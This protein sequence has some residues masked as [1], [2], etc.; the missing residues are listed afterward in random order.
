MVSEISRIALFTNHGYAGVDIPVGG[1]PDTGGQNF[2]VNSLAKALANAG[3]DVTIFTRGGFPFFNSEKIRE[4]TEIMSEKIRYVFVPGGGKEFIRKEDIGS[5]LDEQTAWLCDYV[6]KRAD[7]SGVKPWEYF[8]FINT[9]YWDAAV[10]TIKLIERWK[11]KIAH[12]FLSRVAEGNLRSALQ[13]FEEDNIH[14]HSLSREI[15][16]HVGN[17][18]KPS[19]ALDD[20]NSTFKALAGEEPPEELNALEDTH[21]HWKSEQIYLLGKALLENLAVEGKTLPE[22]FTEAD[23][24]VWT[25]HSIGIIKERNFWDK[26][27]ETVRKLK[28][29]ERNAYEEF[30]CRNTQ[31]HCTT[32]SEVWR[33]LVSYHGVD[34]KNI[35]DFPPCIDTEIFRPRLK[36]ELG[37]A[38]DY[39][40]KVSNIPVETLQKSKIVF[41]TSRMDHTKRKDVLLKSFA[42]ITDDIK[43]AYLFIGGG[44][45]TSEEFKK[46]DALKKS[47]PELEGRAFLLGF[48]P[49]DMIAPLFSIEDLFVSASEMEGFGMSVSQAAAAGVALVSSDLIPFTMQYA[50]DAAIVVRAGDVDGFAQAMKR[51]LNDD[52]DR[53]ERAEKLLNIASEFNWNT[54]AKRFVEWYRLKKEDQ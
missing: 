32:S 23:I 33:A 12:N 27:E 31:L 26:P 51:L 37:E 43:D 54:T 20:I 19:C 8:E 35:F 15:F 36:T 30:V 46:L 48:I 2:Y 24:H 9:H 1:A 17:M 22:L 6:Q 50:S 10:I 39:L 14:K 7:E 18:A 53:M 42:K 34:S 16:F 44:P 41:E 11:D 4:G 45:N 5:A 25:P 40:S 21:P 29:R 38:Y 13:K 28:F 52:K 3:F 49:D 47:M